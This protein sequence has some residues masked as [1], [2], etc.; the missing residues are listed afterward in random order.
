[1]KKPATNS[2]DHKKKISPKVSFCQ[3]KIGVWANLSWRRYR[4]GMTWG[5][6]GSL[7]KAT[8]TVAMLG[9]FRTT[10]SLVFG[11]WSSTTS[12]RI[13]TQV[14][15]R[16]NLCKASF[17]LIKNKICRKKYRQMTWVCKQL[18]IIHMIRAFLSEYFVIINK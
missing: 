6:N 14:D 4:H 13:T 11:L 16:R 9:H 5:R 15:W 2:V 8:H 3:V 18:I 12:T 1:M 10:L 17:L 7:S